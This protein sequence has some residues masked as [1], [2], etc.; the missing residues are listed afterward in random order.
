MAVENDYL[1]G[2][3][4]IDTPENVTFDYALA[5]IGNR[6]IAALIDTIIL[7]LA[8]AGLN[9]ILALV[10]DLVADITPSAM[11]DLLEGGVGW[12]GGVAIAIYVLLNFC[13][14]WGYYVVFEWA[15]GGQTPGKRI[16]KIRVVGADGGPADMTAIVVRNLVRL[17]DMLP[18]A[19]MAGL[20]TM[21]LN[22]WARRLGDFAAGTLVVKAAGFITLD[23]L[24]TPSQ[25]DAPPPALAQ[26]D[27]DVRRLTSTDYGL[28]RDLLLRDSQQPLDD[29]LVVRLAGAIAAKLGYNRPS[30]GEAR[31]F[32][33]RVAESYRQRA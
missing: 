16:A 23:S 20:V 1:A 25:I 5:D 11:V 29:L 13:V 17:I 32:L 19:Y 10:L 30:A 31:Q 14:F 18:A 6:F 27:F 4:N 7:T 28:V 21:L 8:L 26:D 12:G 33:A 2:D 3:Y 15:W 9:A 24:L 22:P